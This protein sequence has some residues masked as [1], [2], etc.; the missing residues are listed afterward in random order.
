LAD[1]VLLAGLVPSLPGLIVLD[2]TGTALYLANPG[3]NAAEIPTSTRRTP[4]APT[5]NNEAQSINWIIV[6]A[7]SFGTAVLAF[8]I[9]MCVLFAKRRVKNKRKRD[10]PDVFNEAQSNLYQM[11]EM[12]RPETAGDIE[13]YQSNLVFILLISSGAFGDVWKGTHR[14]ITVAIKRMKLERMPSDQL[15]FIQAVLTEA[16]IMRDMKDERVVQFIG[17]DFR[18]VSI[19]MELMPLGALSSFIK[20][21]KHNMEWSTRYQMM[22]DI[23]DGMSY[24]HSPT[25]DDGTEKRELFHQDLKSANV[26]LIEVDG[27]IRAKIADFGLSCK[28]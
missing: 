11:S 17:F 25:N 19:I 12:V 15:K 1:N 13:Q 26:L 14:D 24:L 18:T 28:L 4:I 22:L 16:K 9:V 6:F 10:N 5:E 27:I 2:I 21:S 7:S 20:D 23:C 8:A 3:S